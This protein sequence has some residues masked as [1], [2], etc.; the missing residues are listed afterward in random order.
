[1]RGQGSPWL[2]R[3]ETAHRE[4]FVSAEPDAEGQWGPAAMPAPITVWGLNPVYR[5]PLPHLA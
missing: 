1:M 2:P 3:L 5:F 4:G